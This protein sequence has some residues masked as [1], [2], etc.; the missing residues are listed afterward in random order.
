MNLPGINPS[1][2]LCRKKVVI[3]ICVNQCHL[4]TLFFLISSIK[5][6]LCESVS[7]VDNLFLNFFYKK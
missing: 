6:N 1:V 2:K 3:I 4:W 5:N 7:S